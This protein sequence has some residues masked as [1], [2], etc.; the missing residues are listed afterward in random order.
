MRVQQ[1]KNSFSG[2]EAAPD[3]LQRDDLKAYA[4]MAAGLANCILY[5]TG[6][7]ARAPGLRTVDRVRHV[8][9]VKAPASAA[10]P[11]GGTAAL[12]LDGDLATAMVT[13]DAIGTTNGYIALHATFAAQQAIDFVDV[14]DIKLSTG[15]S[16]GEWRIQYSADDATFHDLGAPFD[17]DATLRT[18]RRAG[19]AQV[20]AKYWRLIRVGAS[21]LGAATLSIANFRFWVETAALSAVRRFKF[22]RSASARYRVVASDRNLAIYAA[23][24]KA[25]VANVPIPHLSA[26]LAALTWSQSFDTAIAYHQ[27]HA[28][29]K[30]FWQGA[31]S[32]WDS[33]DQAFDLIPRFDF[34]AGTGGQDCVQVLT[35]FGDPHPTHVYTFTLEGE[36]TATVRGDTDEAALAGRIQDALN[37]LDNVAGDITVGY[38][39]PDDV[40]TWTITFA[41]RDGNRDWDEIDAEETTV[42]DPDDAAPPQIQRT[43]KGKLPGEDAMSASRGWPAAGAFYGDRLYQGGMT[44]LPDGFVGSVTSEYFNLDDRTDRDDRGFL[45]RLQGGLSGTIR[46]FFEGLHLLIITTTGV[47][48]QP[49]EPVT[50]GNIAPKRAAKIPSAKPDEAATPANVPVVECDG[51]P[52]LVSSVGQVLEL[53]YVAGGDGATYELNPIGTLSSHLFNA[54]VDAAARQPATAQ[55]PNLY[56]VVNGDGTLAMLSSLRDQNLTGW[57]PRRTQG[58][59]LAAGDDETGTLWFA[60]ERTAGGVTERWIE[61]EDFALLTD[62]ATTVTIAA[63]THSATAAQAVFGYSFA[64]PVSDGLVGVRVNGKRLSWP[65]DYAVDR[66]AKTV[67]L[68]LAAPLAA[69]DV[70]RLCPMLASVMGLERFNGAQVWAIGDDTPEAA[71]KTVSGG[72]LALDRP[73]DTAVEVGLFFEPRIDLLPARVPIAGQTSAGRNLRICTATL[74]VED[75]ALCEVSANGGPWW[76]ISLRRHGAGLL[77]VPLNQ[78]GATRQKRIEGL[79]GFS[80]DGTLSIRQAIPARFAI[81]AIVTEVLI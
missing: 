21:D 50:P 76:Q 52:L 47:F 37:D 55:D 4:G 53:D 28:Q 31:D 3:L 30:I 39:D 25:L 42:G 79:R 13:S 71:Q 77:D 11:H 33:R 63:E 43:V 51:A 17:L 12:A 38:S 19:A 58:K 72:T 75:M 64:S 22:A 44:Q 26:E 8:L 54:P 27:A 6:K 18:R 24:T 34:G 7:A 61:E 5:P 68:D 15:A 35:F 2:G 16:A 78:S 1:L 41:G 57:T 74:D 20:S 36:T 9:E 32:E 62:G 29:R 60:V 80:R 49:V 14:E 40:K 66:G 73:A 23:A 67:T 10:A 59:F 56:V 45:R 69:G 46:Q 81:K 70:V 48:F 65:D